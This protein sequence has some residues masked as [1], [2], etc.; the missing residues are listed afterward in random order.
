MGAVPRQERNDDMICGNFKATDR[1]FH[2]EIRFFGS[3]EKVEIL[4]ID[5]KASDKSP[6]YRIV[7]ADNESIEFGVGWLKSGRD[8]KPYPPVI[9]AAFST[10]DR[11]EQGRQHSRRF[12]VRSNVEFDDD[13]DIVLIFRDARSDRG[14]GRETAARIAGD[15]LPVQRAVGPV[16]MGAERLIMLLGF[17]MLG[18]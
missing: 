4:R 16:H 18:G 2:G 9:A 7:A 1:G 10:V 12:A 3:S 6:D 5:E 11:D 8:G 15:H 14:S 13:V 17:V